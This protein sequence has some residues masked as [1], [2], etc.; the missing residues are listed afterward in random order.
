MVFNSHK[1]SILQL[2]LGNLANK[3]PGGGGEIYSHLVFKFWHHGYMSYIHIGVFLLLRYEIG[4][5]RFRS[6]HLNQDIQRSEIIAIV[7]KSEASYLLEVLVNQSSQLCFHLS[8]FRSTNFLLCRCRIYLHCRCPN[9][10]LS[11]I[12]AFLASL[13]VCLYMLL[14]QWLCELDT[15]YL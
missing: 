12:T 14:W 4:P 13:S 11:P 3:L 6:G 9:S 1:R 2:Y 8:L 15:W 7:G 10:R 5:F